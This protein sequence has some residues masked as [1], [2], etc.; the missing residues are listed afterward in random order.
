MMMVRVKNKGTKPIR[1]KPRSYIPPGSVAELD[2][3]IAVWLA[4]VEKDVEII[5]PKK[6]TKM[7]IEEEEHAT[8]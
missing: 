6:P 1:W 4:S 8:E 5:S 2:E 3:D 7:T